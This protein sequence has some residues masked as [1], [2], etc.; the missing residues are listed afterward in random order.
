MFSVFVVGN[1]LQLLQQFTTDRAAVATAVERACSVLDPRG[2]VPGAAAMEQAADTASRAN[3]KAQAAGDAAFAGGGAAAG[4][5]SGQAAVDAGFANVEQRAVDMAEN[6]ERSQRGNSSLFGLFAL[7][8]Q[9]QR[10]A[11][12]KAIVYF[13]EGLQVPNQLQPLYRSVVSEANRANLSIYSV[14]ARGLRTTSDFDRT[15]TDLTKSRENVRRQ[16]QSRGGRAV[17]R[18]DVLAG[19]VA[20]DAI[21]MNA[22]GMLGALSESTGGR[23]IA[24]S[25][26]VRAGLDRAVADTSGYYEITYDPQLAAFDGS[27]RRIG[28]KVKRPGTSVQAREGYFALPPGEGSVDFP[29]ELPL[30]KMLKASPAPHDFDTRAAAYHFGPEAGEVRYTLVAEIPLD[31]L[32]FEG[33]GGTRKAHFSVLAVVRDAK[34]A[35]SE[36]FG[37]DSPVEV[38][39]KSLEALKHGNAVFTRSFT[40]PPGRYSRRARGARPGGAAGLGAQERPRRPAPAPGARPLEPRGREADGA[41]RRGGARVVGPAAKRLEPHRAVRGRAHAS[42]PG[43]TVSLFLV[44]YPG[45][46]DAAGAAKP[47]LTLEFSRDGAVVGRSTAELPAPD[48]AGH[49]PYVA[50]VPTQSLAPGRY[51][52]AATVS[53]GDDGG[54]RAGLLHDRGPER[55]ASQRDAR[56]TRS[57]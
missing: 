52:V 9:E 20:E 13:S 27:F 47:S 28:V 34:G 37:Q 1:R 44:A 5:A 18:E 42:G 53:Q 49:I 45:A 11:G 2:L 3:D 29:W 38:P 22:Q 24:N 41:G 8:R 32:A 50:S 26:D 54:P 23:L 25:N 35:V 31:G 51:E 36:H 4:A 40:L 57:P 46:G 55:A 43:E 12:R 56:G 16:V 19:E 10:L 7:A 15:R 21:T 14:D 48:A 6:V 17:T 30:L 39:E 33:K